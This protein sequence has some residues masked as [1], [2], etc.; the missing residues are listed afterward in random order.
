M[1][2]STPQIAAIFNLPWKLFISVVILSSDREIKTPTGYLKDFS[3]HQLPATK[4]C[5]IAQYWLATHNDDDDDDDDR[6]Q[7]VWQA[8]VTNAS[9]FFLR[10]FLHKVQT[11]RK[12]SPNTF[13]PDFLPKFHTHYQALA[14]KFTHAFACSITCSNAP[15]AVCRWMNNVSFYATP[16]VLSSLSL[17]QVHIF[18]I[19]LLVYRLTQK[20]YPLAIHNIRQPAHSPT[21]HTQKKHP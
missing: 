5:W 14:F 7:E 8:F 18:F 12:W 2:C 4:Q 15:E 1:A 20:F 21:Q 6:W 13:G 17:W 11:N 19:C 3:F 9:I 16:S 10:L